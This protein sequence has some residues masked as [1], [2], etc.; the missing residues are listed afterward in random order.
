[1]PEVK[2]D[3]TVFSIFVGLFYVTENT[4]FKLLQTMKAVKSYKH[5]IGEQT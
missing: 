2:L 5:R 3:L 1:M 4:N